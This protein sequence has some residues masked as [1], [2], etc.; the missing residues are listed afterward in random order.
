MVDAVQLDGSV[1]SRV[2]AVAQEL[3]QVFLLRCALAWWIC[4]APASEHHGGCCAEPK[5]TVGSRV[6]RGVALPGL[7]SAADV[8]RVHSCASSSPASAGKDLSKHDGRWET[9]YLHSD[10]HFQR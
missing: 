2:M 3:G 4:R 7:L 9:L 8:A 1:T 6:C 5:M 10:G